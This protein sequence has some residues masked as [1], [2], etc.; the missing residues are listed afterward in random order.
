MVTTDPNTGTRLRFLGAA[1]LTSCALLAAGCSGDKGSTNAE[2]DGTPDASEAAKNCPVD[3]LKDVTKPVEINLWFAF[4]GLT[5]KAIEQMAADYNASQDKVKVTVGN[6]GSYEEQLAKY[7][8]GLGSPASLP[9]IV[10]GEDTWTRYMV[11]SKSIVTAQDCIDADPG[12]EKIFEDLEPAVRAS[13]SENGRLL[14]GGFGVSTP[15]LYF[16]RDHFEKAGLDVNNPPKTLDELTAAAEKIKAANIPGVE[17][18]IVLKMDAWYIEHW[19]TGANIPIV[20]ENN[21]KD[22]PATETFVG[23]EDGMKLMK[24]LKSGVDAGLI[25]ATKSTDEISAYFAVAGQSGSML[26]QTSSAITTIDAAIKGT[27]NADILPQAGGIDLSAVKVAD[28]KVGVAPVPGLKEAGRGQIGGNVWYMVK[29]SPE[30]IAAAWD[31]LKFANSVEAQVK[32]TSMSGYLPSHAEAAKDPA[33]VEEWSSTDKG[34]WLK[35]AYESVKTLDPEFTGPWIGAYAAF[36][37]ELRSVLDSVAL[38]GADPTA[39]LTAADQ[40]IE[41]AMA[42]YNKNPGQS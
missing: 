33:L 31:F 8:T 36:R 16:N 14:A 42:E 40:A 26:L 5:A 3:A 21:G 32:W 10:T 7:K 2:G 35:V 37:T 13:Y 18:P 30:E 41:E 4:Q 17:Q 23:D 38:E 24:W 20:N 1:I 19:L 27:L 34:K 28:L 9:G 25:K 39:T 15:V 22:A 29:K 11:D 12:S 6:Q